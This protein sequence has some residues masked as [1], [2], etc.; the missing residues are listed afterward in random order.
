M[1]AYSSLCVFSGGQGASDFSVFPLRSLA[2]LHNPSQEDVVMDE[3][4]TSPGRPHTIKL[5]ARPADVIRWGWNKVVIVALV[6]DWSG[7]LVADGTQVRFRTSHETL[8]LFADMATTNGSDELTTTT[9]GG[10]VRIFLTAGI[11][12]DIV[13][14]DAESGNASDSI[15]ITFICDPPHFLKARAKSDGIS[16]G[17]AKL[18]QDVR[19]MGYLH[20]QLQELKELHNLVQECLA[21]LQLLSKQL[22]RLKARPPTPFKKSDVQS[23]WV[24]CKGKL[25]A[26]KEFAKDLQHIGSPF[27]RMRD[28]GT[29]EGPRWWMIDIAASW[30]G[31]AHSLEEEDLEGVYNSGVEL[32]DK[33]LNVLDRAD[34]KLKEQAKTLREFSNGL[35]KD[36]QSDVILIVTVTKVE[37]EAVLGVFAPGEE[38][39]RKMTP[40][41]IYYDL[42]EHGGAP[43]YMVRSEMGIAMPGG[44]LVT[45]LQAIDELH[46]QA[47]IM[48]GIAYGLLP[49]K[50]ELGDI[51]IAKQLLYYEPGKVDVRRGEIPR[52]DRITASERLLSRFRDAEIGWKGPKTHF[53]LVLSGEKLVNDPDFC[54]R[55][56]QKE[57]EAIGGEM[58]GAGL[59]VAARLTKTDWIMVKAIC[60]WANGTKND[61]AQP[62]AAGNA[63][64][65]LLR[66]LQLGRWCEHKS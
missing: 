61:D 46:P 38:P 10:E 6:K 14:V 23:E 47:V 5:S 59:Y 39:K 9:T 55:L 20:E 2:I 45:V 60:D 57:P 54:K 24:P 26:L 48:C 34:K 63:A 66:V 8:T 1:F 62:L 56:L 53:G 4:L 33:C 35:Q 16:P 36:V 21:P 32:M 43:V 28:A 44:A 13:V 49:E 3:E 11:Q 25:E 27:C 52:G 18:E 42:G 15:K 19:D 7:N 58:E 37:A 31:F 51:L 22:E 64:E 29:L 12:G 17:R 41:R 30:D 50:Q 65:F 40:N